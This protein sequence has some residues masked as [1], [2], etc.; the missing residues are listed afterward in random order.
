MIAKKIFIDSIL[1]ANLEN[2]K[3]VENL[4]NRFKKKKPPSM[5]D[6]LIKFQSEK[7]KINLLTDKSVQFAI[8]KIDTQEDTTNNKKRILGNGN[9]NCETNRNNT[10]ILP[11]FLNNDVDKYKSNSKYIN[12]NTNYMINSPETD[13]K[14]ILDISKNNEKSKNL[15]S[16]IRDSTV[17]QGF[18][19]NK[20]KDLIKNYF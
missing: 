4:Q 7:K 6:P 16:R 12:I 19:K 14:I 18:I 11:S 1:F 15:T 5:S 8:K 9:D 20:Y 10:R 13:M 3:I 2:N 17:N